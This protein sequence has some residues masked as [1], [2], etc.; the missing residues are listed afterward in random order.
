MSTLKQ[1]CRNSVYLSA[2]KRNVIKK[3][4]ICFISLGRFVHIA[5][6]LRYFKAAGHDVHFIS[7]SPG[8][9]YDVTIYNVGFGTRYS[10]TQDKW[11]YPLS[12][13]RARM[14]V[15]KLKPDIVHTHYIT[16]G[17]LA[18]LICD[19]HP[20]VTTV[21]GSDLAT[22]INSRIWRP[23]LKAVFEHADCINTCNEDQKRKVI[24]LGIATKKIRVLTLG[25]DT[26]E[27]SFA[28]RREVCTG[29]PLRLVSTRRLEY[30]Y[31]H[32][33]VIKALAI[34]RSKGIHF[35]MTFVGSGS[36]LTE[37]KRQVQQEGLTDCVR[38]L[39]GVDK[40]QI[41]ESL[42]NND[43]FL[44]TPL[45]DGISIA[46]LEAMATGLFPIASDIEVNSDWLEDG[47]GGFLHKVGDAND[48]G[49]CIIRLANNPGIATSAARRNR[50]KVVELADTKT[51]MKLLEKIYEELIDKTHRGSV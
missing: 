32:P 35:Q 26:E 25:V 47:A 8:P 4:R 1:L 44:S 40:D 50:K 41:V 11:K 7:L 37:L 27:F 3:M 28:E 20:T 14:L 2:I 46:L 31:D 5:P 49:D 17:G 21:H 45:W 38:F 12:F 33:T 19:Y 10:R 16:S 34:V 13:L 18:G 6:Y 22:K 51:N 24:S 48:L 9:D 15:K 42:R 36:L 30:V 23:L 39:G 43:V 29:Q